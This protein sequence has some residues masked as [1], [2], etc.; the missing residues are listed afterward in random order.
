MPL[1]DTLTWFVFRTCG[2]PLVVAPIPSTLQ[3]LFHGV[4]GRKAAI[5][6][7]RDLGRTL[8]FTYGLLNSPVCFSSFGLTSELQT[9][10]T[11]SCK[12]SK[13]LKPNSFRIKPAAP[14]LS[15]L[16]FPPWQC[17]SVFVLSLT[18]DSP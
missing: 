4:P 6:V 16:L 2:F 11:F 9:S 3:P 10:L 8:I 7:Y 14:S 1:F 12:S 13:Y 18:S 15:V 5:P 17:L